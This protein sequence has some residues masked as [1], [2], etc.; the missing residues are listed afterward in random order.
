MPMVISR[1]LAIC[2]AIIL[3][4]TVL[5]T[6]RSDALAKLIDLDSAALRA[7]RERSALAAEREKSEQER[8][9]MEK[10]KVELEHE[11]AKLEQEVVKWEWERAMWE[12]EKAKWEQDRVKW[13]QEGVK[14]RQDRA[15]WKQDMEEWE[16]DRIDWK[17]N[18]AQWEQDRVGWGQDRMKWE[19]EREKL[20]HEG[21]KLERERERLRLERERWEKAKE[22]RIPQGAFWD[23]VSPA[24]ACLSYGKR[25]YWATL[26]NV[27]EDWSAMDACMSMPVDI[28]GVTVR[29][30]YRCQRALV[31][32][33]PYLRGHWMVDWDQPDCKPWY[34]D[35]HDAVSLR[36]PLCPC[37]W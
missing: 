26:Q 12:R 11:K 18:R 31:D 3:L 21:E 35:F 7:S 19:Q 28:K 17:L 8:E 25:E 23:V 16:Q 29:R 24:P 14:L 4:Q 9:K 22:D 27:P 32:G 20:E 6:C 36:P 33:T 30:P 34:R 10:Q 1:G 15:K 13:E 2:L 5:I 37:L